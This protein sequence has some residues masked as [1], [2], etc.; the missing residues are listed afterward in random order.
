MSLR[1]LLV[2]RIAEKLTGEARQNRLRDAAERKRKADGAPHVVSY[3][4][5][6][7]D[8]YSCLVAQ[9]LPLL[10]ERY[11]IQLNCFLVS[12]PE[13]WAAPERERLE[14]WSLRD[15][16]LLARKAGLR[17]PEAATQPTHE[18][19]AMAE[20]ALAA[21]LAAGS[22]VND[23]GALSLA[24][25]NGDAL[26]AREGA[27][28]VA[29]SEGD[30]LR[31]RLGHYLGGTLHYGGEWYW[32]LDRLHYLEERLSILGARR[33]GSRSTCLYPQPRLVQELKREVEPRLGPQV[34]SDLNYYLSFR[35][36]YTWIAADRAKALAD[37]YGLHLKLR[38]VLPMIMRG[39]PVPKAKRGYILMDAAREARRAG[40]PFGRIC[41]PVGHPVERGYSLLPWAVEQGKGFEYCRAF[42]AGVWSQGIDAA[43]DSGMHRIVDAAGL[44]WNVAR[45]LIGNP[46]W[47]EEAE[48]NRQELMAL[49]LWGVPSF[50]FNAT[51]AWGQ[52]RLWVIEDAIR[53]NQT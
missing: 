26:P 22:F 45:P 30:A 16:S 14:G 19:L 25:W 20:V 5:Q 10:A 52:D 9:V 31:T 21:S 29:K 36:P 44:D 1:S 37:A 32:G 42:M 48:A 43:T 17:F 35:S 53:A 28:T 6:A 7:D 3:F 23:A 47:R 40:V 51:C 41:D 18:R 15:A 4:H 33:D 2:S 49:G 24:L 27:V 46:R 38:F 8:P 34:E 50:R 12:Q 39:L 13:A 11:N